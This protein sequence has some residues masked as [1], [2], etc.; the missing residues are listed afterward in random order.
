MHVAAPPRVDFPP[1]VH[2]LAA[3]HGDVS[4]FTRDVPEC[5]SRKRPALRASETDAFSELKDVSQHSVTIQMSET[6][7]RWLWREVDM[8]LE[9]LARSVRGGSALD[10]ANNFAKFLLG[11]GLVELFKHNP[12]ENGFKVDGSLIE[13]KC[14]ELQRS[15]LDAWKGKKP[16]VDAKDIEAVNHKLELIAGYLSKMVPL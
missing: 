14:V 3:T 4:F 13:W 12:R 7:L 9:S 15:V 8:R 6:E 16:S 11:S 10:E 2:T 1:D 5:S